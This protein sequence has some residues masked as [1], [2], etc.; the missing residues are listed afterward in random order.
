MSQVRVL[1]LASGWVLLLP[2]LVSLGWFLNDRL[3]PPPLAID[4]DK[5]I[6][7][8]VETMRFLP[9]QRSQNLK[10]LG[11]TT[12]SLREA[13]EQEIL[14]LSR[15]SEAVLQAM[16]A[17]RGLVGA[18]FCDH[19]LPVAYRAAS[20]L[21]TGAGTTSVVAPD[22]AAAFVAGWTQ[23]D[24]AVASALFELWERRDLRSDADTAIA[25]TALILGRAS[26]AQSLSEAPFD[27]FAADGGRLQ[28]VLDAYPQAER[29]LAHYVA[30]VIV[31]GELA[32]KHARE[33]GCK[34]EDAAPT[35]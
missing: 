10:L 33:L 26:Q 7:S 20:V 32:D 22:D 24:P 3:E 8:Q 30:G 23:Y 13:C 25:L 11:L 2:T 18:A 28:A 1:L 15:R 29:M 17:N 12:V 6:L 31:V 16:L 14:R 9:E 34:A 5:P 27:R 4:Q 19:N 21:V 35:P